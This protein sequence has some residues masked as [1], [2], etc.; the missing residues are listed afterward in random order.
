MPEW[1]FDFDAE[2]KQIREYFHDSIR[3]SIFDLGE[4]RAIRE[5]ETIIEEGLI[6]DQG[7]GI[8]RIIQ[9]KV[10]CSISCDLI[11][12]ARNFMGFDFTIDSHGVTDHGDDLQRYIIRM[13]ITNRHC[14]EYEYA[15]NAIVHNAYINGYFCKGDADPQSFDECIEDLIDLILD[16]SF[17]LTEFKNGV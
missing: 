6:G 8:P 5:W 4:F 2:F 15:M 10:S 1:T 7:D 13:F 16:D 17:D 3:G 9:I 14:N 11:G 12:N